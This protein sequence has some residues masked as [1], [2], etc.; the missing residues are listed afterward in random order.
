MNTAIIEM[1]NSTWHTLV[2]MGIQ[3]KNIKLDKARSLV[4]VKCTE[5][6]AAT[7]KILIDSATI[8]KA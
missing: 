7:I 5:K 2:S 6:E 4:F 3:K 8:I 1:T